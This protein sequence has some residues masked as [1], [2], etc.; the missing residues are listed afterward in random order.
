MAMRITTGIL[1]AILVM[2]YILSVLMNLCEYLGNSLTYSSLKA[3]LQLSK[4]RGTRSG[5]LS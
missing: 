3:L 2:E 5:R 4:G 1:S